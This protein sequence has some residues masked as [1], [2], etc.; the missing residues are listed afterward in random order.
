M[1]SWESTMEKWNELITFVKNLSSSC[2]YID[3]EYMD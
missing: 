1:I 3:K 2:E